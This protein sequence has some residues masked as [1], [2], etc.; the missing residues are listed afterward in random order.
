[1]TAIAAA[2]LVLS[3]TS[4][5]AGNNAPTYQF[6]PQSDGQNYK[7]HGLHIDDAFIL[8]APLGSSIPAGK[9]AGL[10]LAIYDGEGPDRL[11]GATS[12][13]A[14]KVVLPS[15]GIALQQDQAVYLT[16]PNP[17]IV[18]RG[19]TH[20]LRGGIT[21]TVTFDFARAGDL[22]TTLPVLPRANY[23]ATFSPPPSSATP[24][25]TSTRHSRSVLPVTS[26]TATPSPSPS[27]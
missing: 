3:L 22:T 18:L 9:S 2:A 4:C 11:V 13:S 23:Y 21:V 8:G 19:L 17:A 12:S 27:S 7:F 10:F 26:A 15:G 14:A 6:H 24:S 25:P 5:E 16:G 20:G 1:M